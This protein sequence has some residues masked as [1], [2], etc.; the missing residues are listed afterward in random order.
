M[1]Y[2]NWKE[3]NISFSWIDYRKA[4]DSIPHSW[5]KKVLDIYKI[6]PTTKQFVWLL[7]K[8]TQY[9]MVRLRNKKSL[10]RRTLPIPLCQYCPSL[11]LEKD[12]T[13]KLVSG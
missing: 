4:Y 3:K 9:K 7:R 8:M 10:G 1:H 5:I 11:A 2:K 6:D 12:Q 13:M